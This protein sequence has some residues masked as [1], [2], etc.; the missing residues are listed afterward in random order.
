ME[1]MPFITTIL[2]KLFGTQQERNVRRY[3]PLIEAC[4]DLEPE[5]QAKSDG[6]LRAMTD[7]FRQKLADGEELQ[8]LMPETFAAVREASVR[9]LKMRHF[10]VQL[11]G[12]AVLFEG[13]IAEMATGEGKTLV[14]T[15]SAYL[16]ALAGKGVH[17]I[18]PN[19]Y[20]AKRDS[21]WM[22]PIYE[23]LGL[24]VG[25]IQSEMDP[26]GPD[27]IAAYRC[28]ITYGTNNEFGFDY[29]RDNMAIHP[30]HLV[31]R[32]LYY[33]IVDEVDSIL[34]DEARTPLIIS[35]PAED[36]TEVYYTVDKAVRRL[37][38][39]VHFTVDE[40]D[41]AV[42]LTE[43][44]TERI[45]ELLGLNIFDER[46]LSLVHHVQQ[47]LRAHNLYKR[48]TEYI[49]GVPQM[50]EDAR[51]RRGMDGKP[52]VIIVDEHTGRL[53]QGRRYSDG[54]HQALEAKEKLPIRRESQTLATITFQNYFRLYDVL[55]GMTG[56][57][58][59]EEQ[60]FHEIYKLPIAVIPTN[61]PMIRDD[62]PDVVFRTEREKYDAI[63][64]EIIEVHEA[65]QPALVG[66]IS[67]ENSER[68]SRMLQKKGIRHHVLNAKNHEREAEI[69]L[70]AGQS[71]SVTVA[72]NMAGRG[73]DIKLGEGVADAGGLH[74]IGTERHES[75]RI[76]NQLRGRS[77]RQ[78]DP[79]SSRFFLSLEDNLMRI[80]GG[81]RIKNIADRLGM[82]EGEVLEHKMVSR[83][84]ASAQKRVEGHHFDIRKQIIKYDDVMNKQREVI[85]DMRNE[86]L[87]GQDPMEDLWAM[88]EAVIE[89]I[90][91][92]YAPGG[93]QLDWDF[94]LLTAAL[95]NYFNILL[96]EDEPV[97]EFLNIDPNTKPADIAERLKEIVREAFDA[98][99]EEIGRDFAVSIVSQ[100]MLRVVDSKWKDHLRNMDHL[101]DGIHYEAYAQKDPLVEYQKRA[102]IM[103]EEAYWKIQCDVVSFWSRLQIAPRSEE[104]DDR[105]RV[106]L[107]GLRRR[108]QLTK[109]ERARLAKRKGAP[110]PQKGSQEKAAEA[111]GQNERRSSK[112]GRNDPCPCGSGKK[113]KKCC[114]LADRKAAS[115]AREAE[116]EVE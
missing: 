25:A 3:A 79:G 61:V 97:D 16:R 59:T 106:P 73:T 43:E 78:G 22:G 74:I 49:V 40:K 85:Y 69:I 18:T 112:I 94:D 86:L 105:P 8:Y 34:I 39:D 52:E 75:R 64:E 42:V 15:L 92:T 53:M 2:N 62:C 38:K 93:D 14:A 13:K 91:E 77:G 104:E 88:T 12:G 70:D 27:R 109:A 63:L 87:R 47:A 72:T 81:E 116:Q 10:D 20:L 21:E 4:N 110:T 102:F 1:L 95:R 60:E 9:T 35:G 6:E 99:V 28:D 46:N 36:A 76:D 66:T 5:M 103:F 23:F 111:E 54:L 32:D 83:A 114:M 98:K 90:S 7:I 55:S 107:R 101:K 17:I 84:I 56:T 26:H 96:D 11:I 24:T 41:H 71:G 48:D 68:L 65:G 67:I 19:D 44:G 82:Q 80:F 108:K 45:Q 33:A 89:H 57:A 37:K 30:D 113:Y 51:R 115:E 29:L 31:Q 58:A 50:D 100:L